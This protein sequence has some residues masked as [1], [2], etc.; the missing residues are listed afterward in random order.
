MANKSGLDNVPLVKGLISYQEDNSKLYVS[1]GQTWE[2][3]GE[4]KQIDEQ[5]KQINKLDQRIIKQEKKV[6]AYST[7]SCCLF[8]S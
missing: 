8:T 5:E 2:A 3:L 1:N 4:E 6:F 7:L